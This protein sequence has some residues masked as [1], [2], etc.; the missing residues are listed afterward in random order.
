M[1]EHTQ[2]Y[3][4]TGTCCDKRIRKALASGDLADKT[5][6][7]CEMCGCEWSPEPGLI[8][9]VRVWQARPI[10]EVHRGGHR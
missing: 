6:W 7:V 5:M 8:G 9:G 3:I 10:I 1:A 2:T 4:A